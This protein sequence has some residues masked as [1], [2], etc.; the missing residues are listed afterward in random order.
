MNCV[1][2]VGRSKI[3]YD[4]YLP[5]VKDTVSVRSHVVIAG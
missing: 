1:L 2:V 5:P 4:L 3:W